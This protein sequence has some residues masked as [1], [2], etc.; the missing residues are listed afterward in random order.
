MRLPYHAGLCCKRCIAI[1]SALPACESWSIANPGRVRKKYF[2]VGETVSTIGCI[3]TVFWDFRNTGPVAGAQF[4]KPVVV[5]GLSTNSGSVS[6]STS[7]PQDSSSSCSSPVL[8]RSDGR[9]AG[10]WCDPSKSENKH[11]KEG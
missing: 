3:E 11:K 10:N 4:P 6:S 2:T 1:L 5:P 7:P 9:A 8:E